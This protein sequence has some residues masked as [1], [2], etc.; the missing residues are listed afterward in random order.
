MSKKILLCLIIVLLILLAIFKL[1]SYLQPQK[2]DHLTVSGRVE[3]DEIR[4]SSEIK[5]RLREV[6]IYDGMSVKKGDIVAVIDDEEL[7]SRRKELMHAIEELKERIASAEINIGYLKRET[8]HKIEEAENALIIAKARLRQ[9]EARRLRAENEY[10]RYSNLLGKGVVS[11]DK[12]ESVELAYKVSL[13]EFNT[14]FEGVKT[15]ELS[16]KRAKNSRSIID[17]KQ[18]EIDSMKSSLNAMRERL[19]QVDINIEHTRVKAPSEGVILRKI[20]E[21]GEI[22]LPG[23]VIGIL[24]NPENIYVKSFVPESYIGKISLNME[25]DV[26]SD[27]YRD[28][29]VN[30]YICYISDRAE[31]TPKEVQSYEERVKQV[32]AVKI[33][34]KD[35]GG[36]GI[37]KKGMPVD[38]IFPV[39]G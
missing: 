35:K 4:L 27:A 33:C 17:A 29:P 26:I 10:R 24:I 30:G 7:Q 6:N 12:F 3:A 20:A 31:F 36:Y 21:Q 16:L 2:Q 14:A 25:V 28:R 37:L 19:R 32:F 1:P 13:E 34:F 18:K 23:S 5:G 15:A 39:S 11:K 9:V 22:I 38:V 8:G